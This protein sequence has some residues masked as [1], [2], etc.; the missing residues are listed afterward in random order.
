MI[1][2]LTGAQVS[3]VPIEADAV[4][5]DGESIDDTILRVL[6]WRVTECEATT[7]RG[8]K[9][10]LELELSRDSIAVDV[11]LGD[12]ESELE[13]VVRFSSYDGDSRRTIRFEATHRES[14][15]EPWR[16]LVVFS[17]EGEIAP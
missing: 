17:V 9:K 16:S 15:Q 4:Q 12:Y 11:T 10:W 5:L 14:F 1:H 2:K 3:S 13:P 7:D 8:L 6:S